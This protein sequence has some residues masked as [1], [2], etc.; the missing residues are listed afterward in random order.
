M[1]NERIEEL[2]KLGFSR[3]QKNGMDRLY[4]NA[5]ALGLVCT[6]YN[7]GNISSAVFAGDGISNSLARKLK[8]AK[9]YIDLTNKKIVSDVAMLA[10]A[11]A[12][13][14]GLEATG[15]RWDAILSFT[16]GERRV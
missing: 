9:T 1:T 3:W 2:T 7:T 5:G 4:I 13:K 16:D 12:E 11:A 15:E 10:W 6:Y 8:A 14:A